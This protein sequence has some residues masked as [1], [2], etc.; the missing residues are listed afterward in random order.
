VTRSA[1]WRL[2]AHQIQALR[3]TLRAL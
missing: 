3:S 1:T 2:P